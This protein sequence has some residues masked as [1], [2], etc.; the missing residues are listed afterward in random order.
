MTC[1]TA[2]VQPVIEGGGVILV[3]NS[4]RGAHDAD[5]T[6]EAKAAAPAA[7]R[8][9]E[10]GEAANPG[11]APSLSP[12]MIAEIGALRAQVQLSV[13]QIVL[14]VMNLGRY[15]HL[16]LAELSPL[17]I[18]PLLRDR[19]AI[20]H[21]SARVADGAARVDEDIIAGIAIWASVS[22]AVDARITGQ[23]KAG[24]FPVRLA[25]GDWVSGDIVWLLDII[26]ADARQATSVLANFRQLAGERLV[27]IHPLVGRLIEPEA[28]ERLRGGEHRAQMAEAVKASAFP[29]TEGSA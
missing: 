3:L 11:A 28:L 29:P 24:V 25:P 15:R 26:A 5:G 21:K 17:L 18:E 1:T 12:G 23:V 19:V 20:A 8:A 6:G 9:D 22:D 10:T 14:A 4:R 2:I 7:A 27:K 13:G 16:P